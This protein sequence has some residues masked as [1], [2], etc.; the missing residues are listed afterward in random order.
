MTAGSSANDRIVVVLDALTRRPAEHPWGVR[1]LAEETGL[2][3]STVHRVLQGLTERDLAAQTASATYTGGPRLRVLLDRLHRTHPLL[4]TARPLA[5]ELART[6]DA[7]ILLSLYD[8]TRTTAFVALSE[9]PEGPV[10]YRLDP[11]ST[12]PLHAGAAGRAILAE[13]GSDVLD[14]LDL[15]A[16]TPETV[17]NRAELEE[18]LRRSH[19]DG[20]TFSTGQHVAL[21]AGVAAPVHA[22]GLLGAVSVTRPRHETSEDDLERFA[23]LVREAAHRVGRLCAHDDGPSGA[24]DRRA[25]AAQEGR[26]AT[27]RFER[28]IA[29]LATS[30]PLPTGG[31]AL[32]RLLHGNPATT[33]RLLETALATGLATTHEEHA[34]AGPQLLRWAAALVPLPSTGDLVSPALHALAHETGET[35]GLTEYDPETRTA[36]MTTVVPGS[37]PIH[38]D[39]PAGAEVPLAAG[40]A[41]KAILAFLPEKAFDDLQLVEYTERTPLDRAGIS[42]DLEQVRAYGRALGD[43]ERI[44]DGFGIA[45]PYF[46]GCAVAGSIT[47]TVPRH[48]SKELDI[49]MLVR[50][51]TATAREITQL[52][53][54]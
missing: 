13:L 44:P 34:V 53:S 28:L 45:V 31:R 4:S 18:L 12:I 7:T 14:R 32:A 20:V 15:V 2:S 40:A 10:R 46:A 29:A 16:H 17:T 6:C 38:Y 42:K 33:S 21:A 43:G 49:E 24:P 23:P 27:A 22:P 41:G 50:Q 25:G 11:G 5:E 30:A 1:E 8:P 39:L 47:A 26:T 48:R 54:P 9:V 37:K 3:R 52:L 19:R 51:L 36:R 35:I